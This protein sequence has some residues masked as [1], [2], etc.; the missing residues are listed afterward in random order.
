MIP[1]E[2]NLVDLRLVVGAIR[3]KLAT[4]SEVIIS[5][6]HRDFVCVQFNYIFQNHIHKVIK[7]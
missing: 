1:I 3:I 6:D 4:T 5:Q 7:A 2:K